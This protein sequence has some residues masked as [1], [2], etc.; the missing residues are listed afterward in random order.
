MA[1]PIGEADDRAE[2]QSETDID[3]L[4]AS[5][6]QAARAASTSKTEDANG[7]RTGYQ[8]TSSRPEAS[9]FDADEAHQAS[10]RAEL[11]GVRNINR[12][13]EGVVSSLERAKQNMEARRKLS[14][15]AMPI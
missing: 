4:F 1:K 6:S 14:I 8:T 12:A 13:I 3:A 10:L 7:S 11:E 5:P 2:D 9:R 15:A